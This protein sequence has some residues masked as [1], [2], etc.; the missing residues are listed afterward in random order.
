[1]RSLSEYY[2]E[3]GQIIIGT[4]YGDII[5]HV[6]IDFCEHLKVGDKICIAEWIEG[7][8]PQNP[9]LKNAKW[10]QSIEN[11]ISRVDDDLE[12]HELL[13]DSTIVIDDR[14][15]DVNRLTLFGSLDKFYMG[16][17]NAYL[18]KIKK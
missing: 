16:V 18:S 4:E 14:Y 15:L 9:E 12:L 10:L 1:M 7:N 6:Y 13:G 5:V 8:D 11:Y 3:T 17:L 2:G